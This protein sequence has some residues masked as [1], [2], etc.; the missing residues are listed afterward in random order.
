[1][2]TLQPS[3][4]LIAIDNDQWTANIAENQTFWTA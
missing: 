1:M 4:E 2:F 3:N